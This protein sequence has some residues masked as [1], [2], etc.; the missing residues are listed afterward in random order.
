MRYETATTRSRQDTPTRLI[1]DQQNRD[2]TPDRFTGKIA[3]DAGRHCGI[4]AECNKLR[5]TSYAEALGLIPSV[6]KKEQITSKVM[7]PLR[8]PDKVVIVTLNANYANSIEIKK[9]LEN[10]F[11]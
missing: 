10:I 11:Y 8:D 6:A 9:I 4:K 2:A 3:Q 5:K 1:N 7:K